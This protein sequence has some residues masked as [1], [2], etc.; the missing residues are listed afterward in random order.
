MQ[1]RL[2]TT[3]FWM[4]G[5]A[6]GWIPGVFLASVAI[7]CIAGDSLEESRCVVLGHDFS[8]AFFDFYWNSL[9]YVPM[10]GVTIAVFLLVAGSFRWGRSNA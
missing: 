8:H 4:L 7:G 1:K 9:V 10:L 6:L 2:R 3:G 5:V